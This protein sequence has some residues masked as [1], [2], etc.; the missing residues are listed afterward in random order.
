MGVWLGP[1]VERLPNPSDL[2]EEVRLRDDSVASSLED[3]LNP[4]AMFVIPAFK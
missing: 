1:A 4:H 3:M 2:G